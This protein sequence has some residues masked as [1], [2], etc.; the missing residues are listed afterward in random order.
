M[1][2]RRTANNDRFDALECNGLCRN[3]E[4]TLSVHLQWLLAPFSRGI[5]NRFAALSLSVSGNERLRKRRMRQVSLSARNLV[6]FLDRRC[7]RFSR[8]YE[9]VNRD[10]AQ[11]HYATLTSS[12][13]DP[14]RMARRTYVTYSYQSDDG[15][16]SSHDMINKTRLI[17]F[18][19]ILQEWRFG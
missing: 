17:V 12:P 18:R 2:D 19:S 13:C 16:Y 7:F 14:S 11:G 9:D 10:M 15:T 1:L 8:F 3:R 4:C 5:A 6:P